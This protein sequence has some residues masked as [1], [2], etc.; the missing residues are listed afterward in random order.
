V[1]PLSVCVAVLVFAS[2]CACA[3]LYDIF[4]IWLPLSA[5]EQSNH[6]IQI[7]EKTM[8]IHGDGFDDHLQHHQHI[9]FRRSFVLDLIS[10][11]YR[12][13]INIITTRFHM[14]ASVPPL[15]TRLF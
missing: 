6:F 9:Y 3:D 5:R 15:I 12:A 10:N 4:L 7:S 1:Y 14:C 13:L 2:C 8:V 11:L